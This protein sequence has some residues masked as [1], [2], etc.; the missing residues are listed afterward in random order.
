MKKSILIVDDNVDSQAILRILLEAEGFSVHPA[1]D[2][3]HA[4]SLLATLHPDLIL[5]DVQLP[6]MDGLELTRKLRG[7]PTLSNVVIVG[8]SAYATKD[9]EEQALAAGCQGY[10]TKPIDTRRFVSMINHYVGSANVSP[11]IGAP[12][13]HRELP[14]D[15]TGQ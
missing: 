3:P 1:G 11:A 6:G 15:G 13:I 9:A 2:A 4:L 10:I 12:A 7:D 8:L 5:M 14:E